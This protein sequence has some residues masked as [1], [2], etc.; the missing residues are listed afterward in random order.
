[1]IDNLA[2]M[3]VNMVAGFV[4]VAGFAY[5]GLRKIGPE[6]RHA[7]RLQ[8]GASMA[9]A[10]TVDAPRPLDDFEAEYGERD[11]GAATRSVQRL[12][13][14]RDLKP[15]I[16]ALGAVGLLAF[17]TGLYTIMYWPL[18][19]S[20]NIA[21]GEP[22]TFYGLVLMAAAYSLARSWSLLPVGLLSFIVSID[23][24]VTGV[25]LINL[26]MTQAPAVSG[27]G[28]IFAGLTG[29]MALPVAATAGTKKNL[30]WL[31]A[32]PAVIAACI[33]A[34]MAYPAAW[35]HL[36]SFSTW[37]PPLV[38]AAKAAAGAAK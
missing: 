25:R 29:L 27:L 24:I 13:P 12:D 5:F 37:T 4:I 34:T 32:V 10:A 8:L 22:A 2:L 18:T 6:T 35:E 23:P 14:A 16:T 36:K 38:R 1:M 15:W 11:G 30:W 17:L 20:Y 7:R 28:F 3:L 19:G 21:F 9:G 31:L 33:W 26:H